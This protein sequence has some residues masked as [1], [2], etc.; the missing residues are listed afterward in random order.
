MQE[1]KFNSEQKADDT[2]SS[3]PIAKPN[4]VRSQSRIS[5]LDDMKKVWLSDEYLECKKKAQDEII[6]TLVQGNPLP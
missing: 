5:T 4:V 1:Q 2:A 3:Q 6:K